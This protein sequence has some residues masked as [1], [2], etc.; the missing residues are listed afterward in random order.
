MTRRF[1]K[2]GAIAIGGLTP[3]LDTLFLLLFSVLALSDVRD[4]ETSEQVR[5]ALPRVAQGQRAGLED[6]QRVNLVVDA[7]GTIR[8]HGAAAV[9]R[10]SQELDHE[11]AAV[12]GHS[13]PEDVVVEIRGDHDAPHGVTV[14]LLQHLRAGRFADVQLLAT[15]VD[16]PPGLFGKDQP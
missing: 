8:R 6:R 13:T 5:I 4:P 3:L 10:S 12:M 7:Q 14:Q 1:H 2:R 11:L 15:G 9:I 16:P